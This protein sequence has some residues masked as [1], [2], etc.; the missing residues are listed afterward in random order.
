MNRKADPEVAAI[1]NA[2]NTCQ[3]LHCLPRPGGLFDQDSFFVEVMQIVLVAQQERNEKD[4][5]Q[6]ERNAKSGR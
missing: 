1:M 2:V 5:K 6:A 4:S 3:V